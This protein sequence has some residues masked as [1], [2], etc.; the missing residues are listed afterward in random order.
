MHLNMTTDNI[1]L[2]LQGSY[3]YFLFVVEEKPFSD[4]L[5]MFVCLGGEG[6]Q[7]KFKSFIVRYTEQHKVWLVTEIT[8]KHK[9]MQAPGITSNTKHQSTQA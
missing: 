4:C 6:T 3:C 5:C 1:E 9:T 8:E 2:K 7:F